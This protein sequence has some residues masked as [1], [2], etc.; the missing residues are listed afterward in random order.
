MRSRSCV[1]CIAETKRARNAALGSEL[2]RTAQADSNGATETDALDATR[3]LFQVL[4]YLDDLFG[5]KLAI[6]ERLEQRND[7]TAGHE[8]APFFFR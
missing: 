6:D 8:R 3:A 7:A 1:A 2:G 5:L 4:L